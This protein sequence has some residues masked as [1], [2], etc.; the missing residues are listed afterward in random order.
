MPLAPNAMA[1]KVLAGQIPGGPEQEFPLWVPGGWIPAS[2][3]MSAGRGDD[4]LPGNGGSV[5]LIR[6]DGVPIPPS[7]SIG[8]RTRGGGVI[9]Q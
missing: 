3:K 6:V 8:N 1:G 9:G 5:G 2:G 4:G 7:A